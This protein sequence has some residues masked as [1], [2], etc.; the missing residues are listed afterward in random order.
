M[1]DEPAVSLSDHCMRIWPQGK[2]DVPLFH[3]GTP[4]DGAVGIAQ[5]ENQNV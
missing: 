3:G 2:A 1:T 4:W 5:D